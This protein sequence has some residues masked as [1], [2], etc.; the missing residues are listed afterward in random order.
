[1]KKQILKKLILFVLTITTI[2]AMSLSLSISASAETTSG[3][4]GASG[5]NLTWSFDSSTGTLTIS[6]TGK[7]ADYT[8]N[9]LGSPPQWYFLDINKVIIQDGVTSI[10]NYA[11]NNERFLTDITIPNTVTSIGS[12]AFSSCSSL[13][14]INIPNSV[15]SI[16][17]NAF[18]WCKKLTQISLGNKL[19]SIENDTFYHCEQLKSINIPNTVTSIGYNAFSDCTSLSQITIP[20]SVT[21]IGNNAFYNCTNLSSITMGKNV[22]SIGVYAFTNCN[23]LI[24]FHNGLQYIDK[25]VIGYTQSITSVTLSTDTVGIASQAFSRSPL[26]DITIPDSVT[27][28]GEYAFNSCNQLTTITFLGTRAQWDT[29]TD[30]LD[31]YF[32]ESNCELLFPNDPIDDTTD[33][34]ENDGSQEGGSGDTG[35][36]D[37]GS[38]GASGG[39]GDIGT[40][41]NSNAGAT[42]GDSNTKSNG[43]S[44]FTL[45]TGKIALL[46]TCLVAA[47]FGKKKIYSQA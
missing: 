1:M 47:F 41:N 7:M 15:T 43:C 39:S 5:D 17:S 45:S 44:A 14:S 29:M 3:F 6:G 28:I 16:G 35:S 25:W 8:S 34:N 18:Y 36:G 20:D 22:T 23:N 40:G 31:L 26:T 46:L 42:N 19:T 21:N 13:S 38:G 2:T 24:Q 11:F 10:G 27:S 37:T 33:N 9:P 12:Y 30:G 32:G 4:C